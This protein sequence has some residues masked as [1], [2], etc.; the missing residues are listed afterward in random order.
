MSQTTPRGPDYWLATHNQEV[1]KFALEM[2]RL[3]G[4]PPTASRRTAWQVVKHLTERSKNNPTT[5]SDTILSDY[6]LEYTVAAMSA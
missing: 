6:Q 3:F 1:A 5:S 2:V 4:L